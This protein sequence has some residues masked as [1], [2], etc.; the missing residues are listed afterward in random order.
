M[1]GPLDLVLDVIRADG[2]GTGLWQANGKIETE[3]SGIV[4]YGKLYF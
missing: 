4:L 2:D 1:V 3:Y